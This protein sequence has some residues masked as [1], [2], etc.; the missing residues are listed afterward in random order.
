MCVVGIGL[1]LTALS[2]A[3][4]AFAAPGSSSGTPNECTPTHKSDTGNGENASP[5]P[6]TNSSDPSRASENG[7]GGGLAKGKPAAGTVGNADDK[8]PKGQLPGGGDDNNGYECDGNS[9]IARANPAHTG[10]R[11][12]E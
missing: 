3:S 11:D 8:Q 6:Y 12:R 7:N 2:M 9:G 4:P 5:G 1:P 10:C